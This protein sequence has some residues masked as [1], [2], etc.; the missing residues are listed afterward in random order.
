MK[1]VYILESLD[2]EHFYTDDVPRAISE[3]QRG[4]SHPYFEIQALAVEKLRRVQRRKAGYRLREI[5]EVWLR[6]GICE[7]APLKP[8]ASD[9]LPRKLR[10]QRP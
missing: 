4:R 5:L 7:E 6:P 1:Y 9:A 8:D 3:T 10:R 2:S